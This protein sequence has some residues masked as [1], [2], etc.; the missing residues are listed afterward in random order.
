MA[1][2]WLPLL[3]CNA[4]SLLHSEQVTLSHQCSRNQENKGLMV[5]CC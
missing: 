4:L 1:L 2:P 5:T 3:K